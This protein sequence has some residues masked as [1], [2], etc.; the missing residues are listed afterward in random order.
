MPLGFEVLSLP[1]SARPLLNSAAEPLLKPRR[2]GLFIERAQP[3]PSFF[4][5]FQR[6]ASGQSHRLCPR[7]EFALPKRMPPNHAA[8][9]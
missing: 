8:E 9:K 2:G 1:T 3:P 4:F 7:F 5:I 6:R